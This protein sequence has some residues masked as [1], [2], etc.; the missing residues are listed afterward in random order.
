MSLSRR[1]LTTVIGSVAAI[2][3][4]IG[5]VPAAHAEDAVG[6]A[7][8][9][10]TQLQ[11]EAAEVQRNLE[12]SKQAQVNSQRQYDLTTEDLADQR[13]LVEAM[14]TQVGR[15]AVAAHQ[16][17]AGLGTAKLLFTSDS[18]DSFLADI[19]VMQ[20]I[21]S[22]T[23]EQMIRL[24]AE[25]SR[26]TELETTQAAALQKVTDEVAQ[27]TELAAEYD[28]KVASA[29]Q[30]VNRLTE[31]Q[32]AAL[33]DAQ[34]AAI[35]AASAALFSSGDS[36][37]SRSGLDL[38]TGS[39]QGVWPTTG[40]ITSP[41]GYRT[42]PIGGYSELHDG[43]DVGAACGTPVVASWTGVVTSARFESGWGNRIV[44][45]SGI[46]KAAYNHLQSMS[47]VAGQTVTAGQ[48]IGAVGTTGYSTGCH[49]HFSTW[50]NGQITDPMSIF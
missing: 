24:A 46:Y 2:A 27:Q 13:T 1:M 4:T 12:A 23:D 50:V 44:V 37:V 17:A 33:A 3:L 25:Q 22:I 42:N 20:S 5:L 18:E 31:A 19:A 45:D 47:V 14:R 38:P 48:V 8:K 35:L 49:L 32:K 6:A 11:I 36:G 41:F 16:Q 26:L 10:L 34:N 43:T 7:Q 28:K 29:Q 15:V 30:V 40:P 9:D 39:G 21:T